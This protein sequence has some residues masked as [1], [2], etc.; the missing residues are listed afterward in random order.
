MRK[1]NQKGF[2]HWV[3]PALVIVI[4]AAIGT[5]VL[6][7]GHADTPQPVGFS[8]SPGSLSPSSGPSASVPLDTTFTVSI[9]VS[10]NGNNVQSATASLNYSPTLMTC[11]SDTAGSS[12]TIDPNV[13]ICGSGGY[14]QIRGYRNG[15]YTQNGTLAIVTFKAIAP[16]TATAEFITNGTTNAYAPPG[17]TTNNNPRL[18]SSTTNGIYTIFTP[19]GEQLS[20]PPQRRPV[21]YLH[22]CLVGSTYY[23][24]QG[25]PTCLTGGTS[26]RDYDPSVVPGTTYNVPCATTTNNSTSLVRLVY[27]ASG[28]T[29]PAGTSN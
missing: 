8:L 24:T 18:S 12:F 27:I 5:Y 28:A 4:I 17:S 23:V 6:A 2:A 3:V 22:L 7:G 21:Q 1:L 14:I 20:L 26:V 13:N 11:V 10:P 9:N 29:C 16:G 19:I 25:T 15:A